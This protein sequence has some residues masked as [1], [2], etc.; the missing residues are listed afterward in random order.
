M[1]IGKGFSTVTAPACRCTGLFWQHCGRL[2]PRACLPNHVEVMH[3][4]LSTTSS[5]RHVDKC[6]AQHSQGPAGNN[7]L[8][9]GGPVNCPYFH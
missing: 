6:S 4:C 1:I 9:Y 7:R 2:Q 3:T 8:G 5:P